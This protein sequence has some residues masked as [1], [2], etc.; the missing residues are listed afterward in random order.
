MRTAVVNRCH[1]LRRYT[2]STMPLPI[3][4][5]L[6]QLLISKPLVDSST[7]FCHRG[8]SEQAICSNQKRG[9]GGLSKSST[10]K[11]LPEGQKDFEA[12]A[13]SPSCHVSGYTQYPTAPGEPMLAGSLNTST[14]PPT[15][16]LCHRKS[17]RP[18]TVACAPG[19]PLQLRVP[20]TLLHSRALHQ[21]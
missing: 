21:S 6:N 16:T 18:L 20:L 11:C 19:D 1:P 14:H 12:V 4:M 10:E 17:T 9:L 2:C 5:L 3:D 8:V 15:A 13:R 7:H